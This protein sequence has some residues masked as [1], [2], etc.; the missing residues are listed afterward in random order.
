MR[1]RPFVLAPLALALVSCGGPDPAPPSKAEIARGAD[2]VVMAERRAMGR[3]RSE[4]GVLPG[5]PKLWVILDISGDKVLRVERRGLSGRYETVYAQA[6]GEVSIRS[7]G[8][9]AEAPDADG[10]LLP[11]RSFSASFPSPA[12]M[13]VRSGEQTF[14]FRYAGS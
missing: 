13:L 8:I 10:S 9:D 6:S 3:W 12:K 14:V 7:D 5:D 4:A 1:Q 11:F 2:P